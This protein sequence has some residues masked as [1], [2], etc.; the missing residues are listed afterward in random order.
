MQTRAEREQ[1]ATHRIQRPPRCLWRRCAD[2]QLPPCSMNCGAHVSAEQMRAV[3][4]LPA[5]E[6]IHPVTANVTPLARRCCK[7]LFMANKLRRQPRRLSVV[8]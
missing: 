8:A 1:Q 7:R 4:L 5:A 6:V 2:H 3:H